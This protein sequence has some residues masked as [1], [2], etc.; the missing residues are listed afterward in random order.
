[1]YQYVWFT[2]PIEW[3]EDRW[4]MEIGIEARNLKD[5]IEIIRTQKIVGRSERTQVLILSCPMAGVINTTEFTV[6]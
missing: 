2:R 5:A 4:Q 6:K 1:M 3:P